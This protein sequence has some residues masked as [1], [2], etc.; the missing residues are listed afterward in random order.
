MSIKFIMML[1]SFNYNLIIIAVLIV[2][3]KSKLYF[4]LWTKYTKL[5]IISSLHKKQ[6]HKCMC[7]FKIYN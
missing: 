3:T 4:V 7:E 5:I 1:E 2:L 6:I